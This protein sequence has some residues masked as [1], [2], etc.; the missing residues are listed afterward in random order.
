MCTTNEVTKT[1]LE[2]INAREL[3][4]AKFKIAVGDDYVAIIKGLKRLEVKYRAGWDDYVVTTQKY[5]GFLGNPNRTKEEVTEG[6]YF[7]QLQ[8]LISIFFK[9]EYVMNNFVEVGL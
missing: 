8:E 2:Q 1:I 5:K 3:A 4:F 7:D 6:I 9:F